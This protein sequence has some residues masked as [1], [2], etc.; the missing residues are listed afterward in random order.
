[1]LNQNP[2]NPETN[3]IE[4]TIE[5]GFADK[6]S[7]FRKRTFDIMMSRVTEVVPQ[8]LYY[9]NLP[10]SLSSSHI[11]RLL[12]LGWNDIVIGEDITGQVIVLGV[13]IAYEVNFLGYPLA[14]Q[15]QWI[16]ELKKQML[17]K[18]K[19][20]QITPYSKDGNY[21]VIRNKYNKEFFPEL[22][23]IE[24][25]T[26]H[27]AEIKATRFSLSLQAKAITYFKG[28]DPENNE[29]V[30]KMVDAFFNG[31]PAITLDSNLS[32][33]E[34]IGT[35]ASASM[36]P[37][38]MIQNKDEYNNVLN[39]MYSMLGIQNLGVDKAAGVSKMEASSN[40]GFLSAV[41]N[42]GIN[43]RQDGFNL[44]NEKWGYNIKVG[45]NNDIKYK[46]ENLLL[47]TK[48]DDNEANDNDND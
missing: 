39:E 5:V 8:L 29:R 45:Y 33:K 23:I 25:Y 44:A 38:L 18:N 1:M 37:Q 46:N 13:V 43:A 3:D 11:E 27:L 30:K 34:I 41:A 26:E 17:P 16:P 28:T 10:P 6:V 22:E 42:I 15:I 32:D 9:E 21:V 48:K 14:K 20:K 31:D 40:D 4:E 24:Y 35:I 36:I 19:Y 2:K 47:G 7:N 12:R